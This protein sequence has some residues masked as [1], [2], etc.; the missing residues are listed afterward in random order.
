MHFLLLFLVVLAV[1]ARK[2][3]SYGPRLRSAVCSCVPETERYKNPELITEL[4]QSEDKQ[5][6]SLRLHIQTSESGLYK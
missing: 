1:C 6:C 3:S 5:P 4:R 2:L